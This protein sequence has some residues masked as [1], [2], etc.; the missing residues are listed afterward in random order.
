VRR[1]LA[2]LA[3]SVALLITAAL[4]AAKAAGSAAGWHR[5]VASWYGPGFYGH[6]TACGQIL[7]TGSNWVAH[8]YMR[9]GTRLTICYRRCVNTV[10]ADRGPYVGGRDFDLAPGLKYAVGLSGVGTVRWRYR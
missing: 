2:V 6:R 10:V 7:S 9:C 4:A 5:S 8:K 1:L 3:V